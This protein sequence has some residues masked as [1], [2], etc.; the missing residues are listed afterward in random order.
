MSTVYE[1]YKE[2]QR[3]RSDGYGRKEKGKE[4]PSIE[5]KALTKRKATVNT[6]VALLQKARDCNIE[7]CEEPKNKPKFEPKVKK[8]KLTKEEML[9]DSMPAII[10]GRELLE[11]NELNEYQPV[12]VKV[13]MAAI[14]SK[15]RQ[16]LKRNP[17][18]NQKIVDF[19]HFISAT[20]QSANSFKHIYSM[21]SSKKTPM[22]MLFYNQS[23]NLDMRMNL[24]EVQVGFEDIR[25]ITFHSYDTHLDWYITK[26]SFVGDIRRSEYLFSFDNIVIDVDDHSDNIDQRKLN[27]KIKK[28]ID[29]LQNKNLDFP[30]F[31]VVYTG[32]GIHIWIRLVS[33]TARNEKMI[34]LYD[35]FCEELC[36]I[37]NKVIQD[38]N[39]NLKLD[40]IASKDK[41]RFVRLPYTT[42]TKVKR[43]A[44]FEKLTDKRYTVDELCKRFGIER[45]D[46]SKK[47]KVVTPQKSG[48]NYGG[49][50]TSLHIKR[51]N[52]IEKIVEDCNGDCIGR[53]EV[54]LFHYSNVCRQLFDDEK[55]RE[56][57]QQLNI[58]F[59]EPLK[60]S[61]LE[62]IFR[63]K[64]YQYQSSKFLSGI[65]ATFE[66]RQ[67]YL[68]T[69]GRQS[70]RDKAKKAKEERNQKIVELREN[71]YTYQQIANEVDC[72]ID[73][74]SNVLKKYKLETEQETAKNTD[75]T[76]T[77]KLLKSMPRDIKD[78]VI[79]FY[80]QRYKQKEIA[81]K[82]GIA[83]ST[84]SDILKPCKRKKSERNQTIIELSQKGHT[85]QQ[86]ADIVGCGKST[87]I[88]VL[89]EYNA[90]KSDNVVNA[91][92]PKS[93]KS[94]KVVPAKLKA[95]PLVSKEMLNKL[96]EDECKVFID[97]FNTL[98]SKTDAEVFS[99]G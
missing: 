46:E 88:R 94:V 1:L 74:V 39:I 8:C 22:L 78:I 26:N 65:N 30:E 52:F 19:C 63:E 25:T 6:A 9:R 59:L 98:L 23:V 49:K 89:K 83:E 24:N 37:V 71:G 61:E 13:K 28:L 73:T 11:E 33:F 36:K 14:K 21:K 2:K 12:S 4:K 93:N 57:T 20:E 68:N 47:Q 53:R 66:E 77:L 29:C 3:E 50:Y 86:I 35:T 10:A 27:K 76:K 42:N 41:C 54:M 58:C 95:P 67:L 60:Q 38:N 45:A 82:L 92:A 81:K 91:S 99:S 44:E 31:N 75:D 15:L 32:R 40:D 84:V 62:A 90:N 43:K 69:T 55:A 34:R 16:T 72:H 5:T 96:P 51:M 80:N 79:D 17:T 97:L 7:V 18:K 64:I 70:E 48:I 56:M 85:Q 87:V